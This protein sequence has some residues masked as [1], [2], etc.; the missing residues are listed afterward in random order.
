MERNQRTSRDDSHSSRPAR[1][2]REEG[3]SSGG[4]GGSRHEYQS[5]SADTMRKRGE[6][7]GND[8]DK[9]LSDTVHMFKC[10]GGDNVIRFLPPTWPKPEHFGYDIYVHYGIGPDNQTYLCLDKMKGEDC[11]ICEERARAQKDGDED[12]AKKLEPKKRVLVYLLDRNNEKAG[13]QAW[14]MPWTLDRDI[15]KIS[16][17]KRSGDVLELDNPDEGYDVEF[18]KKGS[19]DRTEYLGVAISRRSSPLDND[20]AL[21][22]IDANPL[23]DILQYYDYDHIQKVF[24]GGGGS[25]DTRSPKRGRDDDDLDQKQERDL[26]KVEERSSRSSRNHDQQ[27]SWSAIHEMSYD[28]LCSVIDEQKLEI[29][30]EKSKDDEDLAD[31]I[32]EEMKIKDEP[33]P[34]ARR[35][36]REEPAEDSRSRLNRLRKDRD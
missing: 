7:S 1:G 19:K 32:C 4:R 2:G 17:D 22:F 20:K 28:E 31:W 34:P 3:R 25:E 11:P 33:A 21:D 27:Y 13:A 23:P 18:E 29:D 12:Y 6:Q 35:S 14:A 9:Y 24:G 5:R 8:Y 26:R 30:P 16:V 36:S 15:C 10:E